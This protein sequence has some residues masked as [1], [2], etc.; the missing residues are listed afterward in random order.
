M[1]LI[2]GGEMGLIFR[3]SLRNLLRQKRRNLFLGIGIA[4]GMMIL[5]I[6]S[7][8]SHGLVDVLINDVVSYAFGHLVVQG[9]PGGSMSHTMISDKARIEEIVRETIKKED[10]INMEENLGM[11]GRGIGNGEADN[12][13]VVGVN[14]T[15]AE[16][17]TEFFEEFFTLVA[18]NYADYFSSEIKYPIIISQQKAE[19]LNVGVNDVVRVRLPMV[20]GQIQAAKLRVVAVAN[21]NNSF[22]DI[23]LFMEAN[24]VKELLGY[25]P[26]Q[27]ASL[28]LTLKNP[29]QTAKKYADLLHQ[30]LEAKLLSIIGSVEGTK[31]QLLA[32]KNDEQAK[33]QLKQQIKIIS[34]S[35]KAAFAKDGVLMSADLAQKL[36]VQVGSKFDYQY[37]TKYRGEYKIDFLIDAIYKSDTKLNNNI[38]L[39][40]G[41]KIYDTYHN[42]I[43]QNSNREYITKEDALFNI[44]A[45]EWRLLERSKDNQSLQKKYKEARKLKT[46]QIFFDLVTM[47]EG[48][49][50]ILKLEGVLN[51][52]T[53]IAVL[54]LFL[55]ILVG[56]INTLRMTIKE[57]TKEIGTIR[58]IGMQKND[59]RNVFILETL[60]LTIISCIL[61][62]I[63]GLLVM[64]VLGTLEFEVDNALSMILKDGHLNFKLN[65]VSIAVNF[66]LILLIAALTAYFP[67]KRAANLTVV[68][69]LRPKQ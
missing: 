39:V 58:A 53:L 42:Y 65:F 28:Q 7:S 48:A 8:F 54:I 40:N 3:L 44:L 25:K 41:E 4:F 51:L 38:V 57:R 52:I 63:L 66:V 45:T 64:Q 23:V 16:E 5:V 43:P 10:L 2:G 33:Q 37:Q 59:I 55:I 11:F 35:S 26:W 60:L 12:V 21:S 67:A 36:D 29:K 24:R 49:S 19:S 1:L 69:A 15:S 50:D 6:A 62:I 68:E 20:T 17:Q 14:T 56:V 61:G 34:G 13:V 18:G 27:S 32:F 31:T 47:Y 9:S 22:M 46:D 30:K